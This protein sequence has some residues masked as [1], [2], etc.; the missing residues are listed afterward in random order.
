MNSQ[1]N[2]LAPTS[3]F[4][5]EQ[6]PHLSVDPM[7]KLLAALPVNR[8]VL[9]VNPDQPITQN[10]KLFTY[11]TQ[12]QIERKSF[13]PYDFAPLMSVTAHPKVRLVVQRKLISKITNDLC[14]KGYFEKL[15]KESDI[16]KDTERYRIKTTFSQDKILLENVMRRVLGL[17]DRQPSLNVFPVNTDTPDVVVMMDVLK[18][19]DQAHGQ[20]L[21]KKGN[22]PSLRESFYFIALHHQ[23]TQGY[24][25]IKD[26]MRYQGI[27]G[28]DDRYNQ[29]KEWHSEIYERGYTQPATPEYDDVLSSKPGRPP[30]KYHIVKSPPYA[31]DEMQSLI[32]KV[33]EDQ[34]T[35]I[36][37]HNIASDL[38]QTMQDLPLASSG[39]SASYN[40]WGD[41]LVV[42][43]QAFKQQREN[44]FFTKTTAR[45]SFDPQHPSKISQKAVGNLVDNMQDR[46]IIKVVAEKNHVKHYMLAKAFTHSA[47]TVRD[48]LSHKFPDMYPSI[49]C[50]DDT[51]DADLLPKGTLWQKSDDAKPVANLFA[52]DI[53]KLN[54]AEVARKTY[55]IIEPSDAHLIPLSLIGHTT[56]KNK[57]VSVSSQTGIIHTC[58]KSG[59]TEVNIGHVTALNFAETP[60]QIY[61]VK[62]DGPLVP[63]KPVVV[64]ETDETY[65]VHDNDALRLFQ[66][67]VQEIKKQRVN[68]NMAP[69]QIL[70]TLYEQ[71]RQKDLMNQDTHKIWSAI[72]MMTQDLV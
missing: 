13:C 23:I 45:R 47:D 70:A 53:F 20:P 66:S 44:G 33:F 15:Y 14:V 67:F 41:P 25:T 54:M 43:L 8:N 55:D 42:Y 39:V 68:H 69:S 64:V 49:N 11:C 56:G 9:K 16:D 37:H 62:L 35:Q 26:V 29:Y 40:K 61:V 30:Q 3:T 65:P 52:T 12:Q 31:L 57:N 34:K 4:T 21:R 58:V 5:A 38:L 36:E 28:N 19:M 24:Y 22:G 7:V 17:P 18:R 71:N 1:F 72:Q 51:D 10:L 50:N 32:N 6:D 2:V 46:G 27:S 48:A 63:I 60:Y 59:Q